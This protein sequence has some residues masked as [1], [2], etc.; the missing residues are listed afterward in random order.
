MAPPRWDRP[1]VFDHRLL[2]AD[3][4]DSHCELVVP[5]LESIPG[6]ERVGERR[7]PRFQV[8]VAVDGDEALARASALGVA[9]V[10]LVL[11]RVAGLEVI[12]AL[13]ARFPDLALL[14]FSV[15]APASEAVA[16]VMAGADHF[17]EWRADSDADELARAVDVALERRRLTR[18]IER[19]E[20]DIQAAR[21][22]LAELTGALE[23]A[24]A[25]ARPLGPDDVLPFDEAA[26][27]Y[28]AGAARAFEGDPRGLAERLGVSYFALR[29]LLAR[30]GVPIPKRP[31][32]RVRGGAR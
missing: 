8:V 28:L 30:Y 20:A 10:D 21:G 4:D 11:P 1:D 32:G 24:A 12:Q 5:H 14:A 18:L 7:H 31:R 9:A 22:Q 19:K 16:A 6:R 15:V 2:L 3:P 17:L 29:R 27:R 26:R 23:R 25:I 13:R